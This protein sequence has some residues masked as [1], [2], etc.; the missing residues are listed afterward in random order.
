MPAALETPIAGRPEPARRPGGRT[1]RTRDT[2]LGSIRALLVEAGPPAA[3]IEAIARRSGVHRT[4]IY[5]RW[6]GPAG[7]V[8][9]LAASI[10]AELPAPSGTT[11]VADLADLAGTLAGLLDGDGAEL[12]RA[13]LGWRDDAVRA[14]LDGFWRSRCALVAQVLE[15][16][17]STA[18][19]ALVLRLVAGPIYYAALIERRAPEAVTLEAAVRAGLAAARAAEGEVP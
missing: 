5:R 2:V 17:G 13:L 1:A 9:E 15:R 6:G 14:V 19:P 12:V 3:T 8:A 18:D 7:V 4:T 11:L 10:D 16:H